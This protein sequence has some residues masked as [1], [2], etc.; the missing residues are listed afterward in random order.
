MNRPPIH[1]EHARAPAD[2]LGI[3][4]DRNAD[5]PIGIQIAWAIRARIGDGTLKPDQQLPALRDLAA[6]TGVNINTAR[7]VYQRLEQDGLIDSRHGTGTFVAATPRGSSVVGQIA[8]DAA[9]EAHANGIDPRDVASALYIALE[10]AAR[11]DAGAERRRLLRMQ[12]HALELAIGE[13]QAEQP[14]RTIKAKPTSAAV[15]PRIL[16]TKELE[17]VR[18]SLLHRLAAL[19]APSHEAPRGGQKPPSSPRRERSPK[20]AAAPTES[21]PKRRSQPSKRVAPASS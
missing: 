6:A 9:R 18:R 13:I 19:Q 4:V 2:S 1:E 17:G 11:P 8:A 16:A 12:I 15:G 5:V 21:K 3:A 20:K 14:R 10:D 7:V